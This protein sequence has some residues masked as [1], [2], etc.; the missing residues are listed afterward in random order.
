MDF[1]IFRWV[2]AWRRLGGCCTLGRDGGGPRV[3]SNATDASPAGLHGRRPSSDVRQGRS[4][5]GLLAR[6]SKSRPVTFPLT[7]LAFGAAK[8]P[9]ARASL[10]SL[11]SRRLTKTPTKSTPIRDATG[12]ILLAL[13]RP[14]KA[15]VG[16]ADNSEGR[17]LPAPTGLVKCC[18]AKPP[19]DLPVPD[20]LLLFGSPETS[21]SCYAGGARVGEEVSRTDP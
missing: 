5:V 15:T 11:A 3:R 16:S 17:E 19:T 12:R 21:T 20:G 1:I 8:A 18:S 10:G 7:L 13:A 9:E 6:L 2:E 4:F 14:F